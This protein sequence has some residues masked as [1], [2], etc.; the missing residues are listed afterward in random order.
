MGSAEQSQRCFALDRCVVNSRFA[1]RAIAVVPDGKGGSTAVCYRQRYTVKSNIDLVRILAPPRKVD[2]AC[3]ALP[4]L[5][6]ECRHIGTSSLL[7]P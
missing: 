7:G 4:E 5:V 2:G 1:I 6:E 3:A